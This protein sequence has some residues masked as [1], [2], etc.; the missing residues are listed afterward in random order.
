MGMAERPEEIARLEIPA[1]VWVGALEAPAPC[2]RQAAQKGDSP[3]ANR[4]A[5]ARAELSSPQCCPKS[6]EPVV[7][8]LPSVYPRRSIGLFGGL[9]A[10][11]CGA[12]NH[13]SRVAAGSRDST[14]TLTDSDDD[15]GVVPAE[16]A[17][18]SVNHQSLL[19][20]KHFNIPYRVRSQR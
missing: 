4:R 2:R 14:A 15:P 13:A 7:V 5:R 18:V 12:R 10:A 20:V 3:A 1:K 16:R 11:L 17:S 8:A 19:G 9:V 6:A